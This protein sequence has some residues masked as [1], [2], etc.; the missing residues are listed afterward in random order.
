MTA[1]APLGRTQKYV[2]WRLEHYGP[3]TVG[4]ISMWSPDY[5]P[6]AVRRSVASL[7]KRGLVKSERKGREHVI[8]L[9][10]PPETAPVFGADVEPAK[11]LYG[12]R[13]I[14]G[15]MSTIMEG[16]FGGDSE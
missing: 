1:M 9:V 13:T 14:S 6:S 5:S 12:A 4:N 15:A 11:D 10:R 8:S 3:S 2:L 7:K 16:L